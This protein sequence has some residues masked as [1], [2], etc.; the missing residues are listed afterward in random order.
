M[1]HTTSNFKESFEYIEDYLLTNFNVKVKL[2]DKNET[3]MWF[4]NLN[5]IIIQDKFVWRN[6]LNILSHELG[7]V[8]LDRK[9]NLKN[10]IPDMYFSSSRSKKQAVSMLNEEITAWNLGKEFLL[11]NKIYFDPVS[12]NKTMNNCIMSYMKFCLQKV[13]GENIDIDIIKTK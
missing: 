5:L 10:V 3:S 4:P 1:A 12:H 2:S 13:Y 8:L 7:H 6:R 9:S 11:E